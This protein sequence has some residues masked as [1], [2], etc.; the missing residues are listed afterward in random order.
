MPRMAAKDRREALIAAAIRLMARDGVAKATTRAIAG[1]A[2][3]PLGVFHYCFASREELLQEVITRLAAESVVAARQAFAG[4]EDPASM[5][6]KSLQVFWQG[7][8]LHPEEQLVGYELAHY[9]LRQPGM[10]PLARRQ[11]AEYLEAIEQLLSEAAKRLGT[12][13][14]APV[15]V[16]ARY[17]HS[18]LDGLT[19]CWIVDRNSEHSREVL[20][21]AGEHL[22]SFIAEP[23]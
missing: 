9:A 23:S 13:W 18:V 14:T 6:T 2:Q 12:E 5:I 21:L 4:A 11:Y 1:E 16:L 3:M 15:P 20:R 22:L 7:V 10:E 17:V 19:M 8:E